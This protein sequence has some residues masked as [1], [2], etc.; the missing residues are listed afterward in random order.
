[1]RTNH[2]YKSKKYLGRNGHFTSRDP[3]N[4]NFDNL[5]IFH[6]FTNIRVINQYRKIGEEIMS[7]NFW[8]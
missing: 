3:E 8:K 7:R 2:Y 4:Q 1:M 6:D 5:D